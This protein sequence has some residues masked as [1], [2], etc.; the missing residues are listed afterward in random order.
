MSLHAADQITEHFAVGELAYRRRGRLY[1][2]DEVALEALR[3]TCGLVLEPLRA[4]VN[5]EQGLPPGH[6]DEVGIYVLPGGGFDPL[7]DPRTGK[8]LSHRKSKTTQHHHGGAVDFRLGARR[9][10]RAWAPGWSMERAAVRAA[11]LMARAG[12]PGGV[13][14]YPLQWVPDRKRPG[15]LKPINDFVHG[16]LRDWRARWTG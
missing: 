3:R 12:I 4:E 1:L 14:R 9:A 7:R 8:W 15:R 10:G 11:Q 13:G 5:A 6:P 2:P 16:D